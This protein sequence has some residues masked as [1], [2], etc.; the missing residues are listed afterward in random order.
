V[1]VEFGDFGC[2]GAYQGSGGG[3][4]MNMTCS[5]HSG[6]GEEFCLLGC[7]PI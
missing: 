2:H 1:V 7:N 6:N 5:S 4:P 3:L